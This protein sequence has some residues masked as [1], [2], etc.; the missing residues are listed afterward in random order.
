MLKTVSDDDVKTENSYMFAN[1]IKT[2]RQSRYLR[3]H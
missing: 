3:K 2:S 1:I